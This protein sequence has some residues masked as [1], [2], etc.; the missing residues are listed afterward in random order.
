M[1]NTFLTLTFL[2]AVSA[3]TGRLTWFE[4]QSVYCDGK[5]FTKDSDLIVA[6]NGAQFNNGGLCGQCILISHGGKSVKAKVIDEC[7]SEYCSFGQVDASKGVFANFAT[8]DTGIVTVS[9]ELV[10]C[11]QVTTPSKPTTI[12][13]PAPNR[14]PIIAQKPAAKPEKKSQSAVEP[15]KKVQQSKRSPMR[16]SFGVSNVETLADQKPSGK[17]E[18]FRKE[19]CYSVKSSLRH[20]SSLDEKL[21]AI[22]RYKQPLNFCDLL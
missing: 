7:P 20:S 21:D 17:E 5:F 9:W 12:A 22:E 8:L 14:K 15:V 10:S 16:L 3:F 11:S 18:N 2:T 4:P 6:I 13:V 1:K 19:A